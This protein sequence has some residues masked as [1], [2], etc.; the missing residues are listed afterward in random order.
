MH[1]R[2]EKLEDLTMRKGFNLDVDATPFTVLSMNQS[3]KD[4]INKKETEKEDKPSAS[5]SSSSTSLSILLEAVRQ[6]NRP[7][8]D[9]LMCKDNHNIDQVMTMDM[10]NNFK[11]GLTDNC[12][13]FN[14]TDKNR[15]IKPRRIFAGGLIAD[16]SW[17]VIGASALET[18]GIF[19]SISFVESNRTQSH[20]PRSVRFKP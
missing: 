20:Q 8:P 12:L 16:D 7:T 19:H 6:V 5:A 4:G 9:G 15:R 18:F 3:N 2:A 10:C 13:S 14:T 1:K 11:C 17:H